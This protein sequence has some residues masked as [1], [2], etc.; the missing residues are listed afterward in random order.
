MTGSHKER[1]ALNKL[2][3]LSEAER[4]RG[5]IAASAGNHAQAV[6]YHSARLGIS[7]KI[8]MP[9]YSPL[10]KIK[11][12]EHWGAEVILAGETFDDAFAYSRVLA[13][14]EQRTYLHPFADAKVV[15][16]QGTLALEIMAHPLANDIDAILVPVGGGRLISGIA[17]YIQQLHPRVKVVGVEE[18]SVNAMSSVLSRRKSR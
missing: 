16:G 11:A 14:E 13:T 10:V 9:K 15:E 6:A 4:Q 2:L 7:T 12:T 5:V 3:S 17:T 18:A 8:V 1:G